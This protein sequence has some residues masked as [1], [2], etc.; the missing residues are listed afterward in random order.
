MYISFFLYLLRCLL[1]IV[2]LHILLYLSFHLYVALYF[3]ISLYVYTSLSNTI[4]LALFHGLSAL[5]PK[6][7]T[8]QVEAGAAVK[9]NRSQH[10]SALTSWGTNA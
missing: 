2:Y 5:W 8:S 7:N 4:C 3:Y 9:Q 10:S 6:N 1:L